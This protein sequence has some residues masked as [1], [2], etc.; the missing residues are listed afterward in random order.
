VRLC[1]EK[2]TAEF[3]EGGRLLGVRLDQGIAAPEGA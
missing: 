3:L 1:L 2:P